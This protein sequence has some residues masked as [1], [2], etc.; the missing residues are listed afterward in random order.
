MRWHRNRRTRRL[1]WLAPGLMLLAGPG[2]CHDAEAAEKL[3]EDNK[4]SKC[5][6]VDRKKDGPAFRDIAAKYRDETD[7]EGKLTHHVTAG[8]MVKFPDGHQERHK[9]VKTG[10]AAETKNLV[11]WIL[12]LPG[13]KKY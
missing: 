4:C 11:S 10:S 6:T 2:W 13:G 9:K 7:A 1:L 8:E 3:V 5:H 12:A